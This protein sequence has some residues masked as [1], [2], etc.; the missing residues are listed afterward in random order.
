[1]PLL[2]P[3]PEEVLQAISYTF[4]EHIR[5][6]PASPLATSYGLTVS[7]MLRQLMLTMRHEER[8]IHED[9]AE[10]RPVLEQVLA[11]LNKHDEGGQAGAQIAAAL[12][13]PVDP[14]TPA[15]SARD[16]WR[17]LRAALEG[18]ITRL[19]A[20]RDAHGTDDAYQAARKAM[21]DYLDRSL[22]RETILIEGAFTLA[23]R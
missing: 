6:D 3:T 12:A 17:V 19:Q 8:A 21:R 20:L 10:L 15:R 9:T 5:P 16:N 13:L 7:N 4:D 2:R 22:D 18:A 1:M 11:W 14:A 23:R